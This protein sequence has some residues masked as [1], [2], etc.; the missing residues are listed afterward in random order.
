MKSKSLW[1]MVLFS[2]LLFCCVLSAKAEDKYLICGTDTSF[3]KE[4]F[5][6]EKLSI[7]ELSERFPKELEICLEENVN[8]NVEVE[9]LSNT[10]YENTQDEQ[11]IF[12]AQFPKGYVLDEKIKDFFQIRVTIEGNR[13]DEDISTQLLERSLLGKGT[14]EEPYR[15][16]TKEDFS[17]ISTN[18]SA[19]YELQN[20]IEL[21]GTGWM[22]IG[23][24]LSPFQ[25]NV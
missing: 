13:T 20:N 8:Q 17:F 7:E 9:W 15:L 18:M 6:S 3:E 4:I 12:T 5:I 16:Y 24:N 23:T 25:G 14:E 19:Y 21:S 22:A 2:S 1:T 10:D 11:Y